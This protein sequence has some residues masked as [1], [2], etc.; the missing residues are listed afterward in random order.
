VAA[1][2]CVACPGWGNVV[3]LVADRLQRD[4]QQ[5]L[6][7][8]FLF[9][10]A[11][12]WMSAMPASGV[13][14]SVADA[15]A[16]DARLSDLE[17]CAADLITVADAHGIVGQSFDREVLAELSVDEVSPLQL[18]LPIAIRF[19]LM[20]EDGSLLTTVPGQVPLTI[21]LE[22]QA[23]DAAPATQGILPDPGVYS[24][25]LP[26]DVARKPDVYR[27]SRAIPL[28]SFLWGILLIDADA[29]SYL[30]GFS[31]LSRESTR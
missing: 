22:I 26:N 23:A 21:S 5:K 1:G 16:C 30:D 6:H 25:P 11:V 12:R 3:E 14:S 31:V 27:C 28:R 29:A 9:T 10:R 4:T 20:H 7:H 17:K 19:D 24:A 15:I 13:R 8:L 2:N 18:L